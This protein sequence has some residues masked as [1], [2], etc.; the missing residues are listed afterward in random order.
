M[1][2]LGWGG[3]GASISWYN[4]DIYK[5]AGFFHTRCGV[6]DYYTLHFDTSL[7]NIF[8]SHNSVR[9]VRSRESESARKS[10]LAPEYIRYFLQ[11]ADMRRKCLSECCTLPKLRM[12]LLMILFVG[13]VN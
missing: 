6:R 7:K 1:L 8:I 9:N 2:G 5:Q 3:G 11:E 12:C 13:C 10:L 4:P